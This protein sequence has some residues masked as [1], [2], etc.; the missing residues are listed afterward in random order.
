MNRPPTLDEVFSAVL[1]RAVVQ[2]R[3]DNA[4]TYC[5]ER[6]SPLPRGLYLQAARKRAF[7]AR[8]QGRHVVAKRSD[9]IAYFESLPL[10]VPDPSATT[11]NDEQSSPVIEM[12]DR[13][14]KA[15]T[16]R[17]EQ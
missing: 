15:M 4:A 13:W 6:T 5:D 14:A 10:L 12:G 2:L 11:A 7:P 3:E 17:R 9:V 1:R 8:R 16:D